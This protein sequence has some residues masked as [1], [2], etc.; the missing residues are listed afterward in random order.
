MVAYGNPGHKEFLR[1]TG[2]VL[3]GFQMNG[4][5]V[6][7]RLK[8]TE[9]Y[10]LAK[11]DGAAQGAS[12]AQVYDMK[13]QNVGMIVGVG[14]T[15]DYE[16]EVTVV[17]PASII[18]K[19]LKSASDSIV[20]KIPFRNRSDPNDFLYFFSVPKD[21]R[22]ANI[23][24]NGC[25]YEGIS[26]IPPVGYFQN[27]KIEFPRYEFRYEFSTGEWWKDGDAQQD[28]TPTM[29]REIKIHQQMQAKLRNEK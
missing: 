27:R 28:C 13:G 24:S 20:E 22:V 2:K 8:W 12:G 4:L 6:N 25:I 14:R 21:D 15:K 16:V 29:S 7:G 9:G 3:S 1:M 23:G 26:G 18:C 5:P 19:I 17:I 11:I 10:F